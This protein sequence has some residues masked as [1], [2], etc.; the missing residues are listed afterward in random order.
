LFKDTIIKKIVEIVWPVCK[1]IFTLFA[2]EIIEFIFVTIKNEFRRYQSKQTKEKEEQVQDN[3]RKAQETDD[4]DE[5]NKL[6]EQNEQLKRDIQNLKEYMKDLES[7]LKN[8]QEK[9]SKNIQ[10]KIQKTNVKDLIEGNENDEK[11]NIK[12]KE[13]YLHLDQTDTEGDK[14]V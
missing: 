13:S 14:K 12:E 2:K 7:I 8:V 4:I 10:D 6:H 11:L 3:I 1:K 5:K 9:T